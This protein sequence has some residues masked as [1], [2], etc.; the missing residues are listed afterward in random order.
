MKDKT[1][2]RINNFEEPVKPQF[3]AFLHLE[4]YCVAEKLDMKEL[5]SYAKWKCFKAL[6]YEPQ[7]FYPVVEVLCEVVP[8]HLV[9]ILEDRLAE[10]I[11]FKEEVFEEFRK[12]TLS[13]QKEADSRLLEQ[14]IE[15]ADRSYWRDQNAAD[16]QGYFSDDIA[17]KKEERMKIMQKQLRNGLRF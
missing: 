17:K 8:E 2:D 6:A 7:G 15:C 4:M 12:T 3:D 10:T 9:A 5:M 11:I 14:L 13:E 1:I 16:V